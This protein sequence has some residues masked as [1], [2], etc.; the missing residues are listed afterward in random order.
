MTGGARRN[1]AVA[2]L[3]IDVADE[4]PPEVEDLLHDPQ[5]SGG[6]LLAVAPD[7]LSALRRELAARGVE[8]WAIGRLLADPAGR[9]AVGA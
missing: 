5:T 4:V 3:P 2:D 9:I 8:G 7:R 6:L 1:R